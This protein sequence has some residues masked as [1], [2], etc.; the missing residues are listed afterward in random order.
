MKVVDEYGLQTAK[1]KVDPQEW[2]EYYH[3]L[4]RFKSG[5]NTKQDIPKSIF[6][7]PNVISKWVFSLK[8]FKI[9]TN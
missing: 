8:R 2:N 9:K 6:K 3:K 1:R 4:I 5:E 7:I